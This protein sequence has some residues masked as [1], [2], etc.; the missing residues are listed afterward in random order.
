M[1]NSTLWWEKC[2]SCSNEDIIY[3]PFFT[4]ALFN[5]SGASMHLKAIAFKLSVRRLGLLTVV[6]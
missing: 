2:K 3:F 1:E 6:V 5:G 4:K